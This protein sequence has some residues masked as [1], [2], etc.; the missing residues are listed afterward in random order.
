[1]RPSFRAQSDPNKTS[2]EDDFSLWVDPGGF[3]TCPKPIQE[4]PVNMFKRS[5]VFGY[6]TYFLFD[7]SCGYK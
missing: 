6:I 2:I 1:M 3:M 7:D 4:L 5:D